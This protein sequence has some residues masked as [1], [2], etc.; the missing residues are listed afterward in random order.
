MGETRGSQ[1]DRAR[2]ALKEYGR[3]QQCLQ[4]VTEEKKAMVCTAQ[5]RRR[6]RAEVWIP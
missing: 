6:Q 4:L 1:V 3:P 5:L 2:A